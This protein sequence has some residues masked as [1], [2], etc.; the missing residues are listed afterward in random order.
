[1]AR[2]RRLVAALAVVFGALVPVTGL[3]QLK[4]DEKS[5]RIL[6]QEAEQGNLKESFEAFDKLGS[7]RD[8]ESLRQWK[9]VEG[10]ADL[11]RHTNPR[12][13]KRALGTLKSLYGFDNTIKY[14]LMESV[15]DILLDGD[16]HGIVRIKAAGLLGSLCVAKELQDRRALDTLMRSA[17]PSD[18]VPPEVAK[19]CLL[20]LGRIG[21]PRARQVVRDALSYTNADKDIQA[22]I[23]AAAIEALETALDR[24][25]AEEWVDRA[26]GS[27]IGALLREKDVDAETRSRLMGI[28][29]DLGDHDLTVRGVADM[30]YESLEAATDVK[31]ILTAL[32]N[33]AEMGDEKAISAFAGVLGRFKDGDGGKEAS[34]VREAVCEATGKLLTVWSDKKSFPGKG[35]G[36]A[37]NLLIAGMTDADRG[38]KTQAVINLGNLYDTRFDRRN[39]AQALV[40]FAVADST[41]DEL[42]KHAIDSLEA[43]TGR[44]LGSDPAKWET[45]ISKS[46]NLKSLGPRTSRRGR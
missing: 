34:K 8:R 18:K 26:L 6:L 16:G 46:R 15:A 31:I 29:I 21:D 19:A 32:G 22:D 27:R 40:A 39:A 20:A 13:A 41:T 11:A 12:K 1:M 45:W 24:P 33:V 2:S 23:R 10:L 35:V 37:V 9:V 25:H 43:I 3:A 44:V 14:S 38:V 36:Q 42:R 5:P 4:A 30:L 17:K 28:A 7:I